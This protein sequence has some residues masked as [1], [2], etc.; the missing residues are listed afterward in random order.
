MDDSMAHPLGF[1][2]PADVPLWKSLA[3]HLAALIL[4]ITFVTAGVWKSL[5]PFSWATMAEQLKVP[6]AFSLA[7]TLL[8]AV[9]ETYSGVLIF[10]PRFRRWGA[11]LVGVLLV[12]FMA[13]VGVNY[14]SLLGKDCSCFPWIKRTVGPGFFVGDVAMLLLA[15]V[16]GWWAR[17]SESLRSASVVLGA[18]VVFAAASFG[19]NSVRQSG[20]KAPDTI[21]ADGQPLSLQQGRVFLFFYD[22]ECSHCDMAAR[23]MA[24]LN[25]MD[26]KVIAIPTR[27]ARFAAAFLHDTGL[28]A[29]TSLDLDL[30][31]KTFPFG[32]PPFGVALD[33]GHERA[34]ISRYEDD[35]P[36]KTLRKLGFVE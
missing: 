29:G 27:Q 35:E 31:K 13:Y 9:A 33:R 6:Y 12:V 32:D 28:K 1:S 22:P 24:K 18:V 11:W 4:A 2:R 25:W 34:P 17:P 16:A 10:V 21:T 36:A 7:L 30:L 14:N 19:M 26:V 20:T 23:K 5:E 3:S 15:T 8:L